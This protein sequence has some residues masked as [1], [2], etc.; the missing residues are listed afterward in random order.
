MPPPYGWERT[1]KESEAIQYLRE[2]SEAQG[3]THTSEEKFTESM[4]K[5]FI[6][7]DKDKEK[8]YTTMS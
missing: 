3:E 1:L 8:R 2:I 5:T 4:I 6:N 7:I